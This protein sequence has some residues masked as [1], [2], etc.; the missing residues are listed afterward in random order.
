VLSLL[1]Q[2]YGGKLYDANWGVRG[3]GMGP[4]AQMLT[5]RHRIMCDK[6]GLNMEERFLDASQFRKPPADA[7]QGQ[8]F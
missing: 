8:L 2:V 6:L 3:R 7:R 4:Y 1:K 5:Q